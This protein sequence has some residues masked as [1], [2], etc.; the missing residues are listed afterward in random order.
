[1]HT[2]TTAGLLSLGMIRLLLKLVGDGII[3]S[4]GH[5]L[6]LLRV[7]MLTSTRW[8]GSFGCHLPIVAIKSLHY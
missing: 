8:S 3:I 1:M 7:C 4:L 6:L 2:Y 5:Y